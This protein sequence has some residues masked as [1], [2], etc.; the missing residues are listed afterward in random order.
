MSSSSPCRSTT[1]DRVLWTGSSGKLDID[2]I[3]ESIMN[4]QELDENATTINQLE[5]EEVINTPSSTTKEQIVSNSI[6]GIDFSKP[7]TADEFLQLFKTLASNNN[8]NETDN[9]DNIQVLSSERIINTKSNQDQTVNLL[10]STT[11]SSLQKTVSDILQISSD[12]ILLP[13]T[14]PSPR[15]NVNTDVST[16][17]AYQ[18]STFGLSTSVSSS[19]LLKKEESIPCSPLS[20]WYLNDGMPNFSKYSSTAVSL[21]QIQSIERQQLLRNIFNNKVCMCM[22]LYLFVTID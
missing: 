2:N 7:R 4:S 5:E 12:T 18:G 3:H 17:T 13:I 8:N 22:F 9:N 11:T 6:P 16:A 20:A 10:V 15:F 19:S 21:R 1:S 14:V